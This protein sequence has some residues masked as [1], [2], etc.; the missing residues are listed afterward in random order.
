MNLSRL[1]VYSDLHALGA[2]QNAACRH[3]VNTHKSIPT[4]KKLT[5]VAFWCTVQIGDHKSQQKCVYY[6]KNKE[7]ILQIARINVCLY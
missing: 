3:G 5:S 7:I 2:H 6:C 4:Y 1:N